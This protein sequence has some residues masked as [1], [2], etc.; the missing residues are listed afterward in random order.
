M[1]HARIPMAYDD[2]RFFQWCCLYELN[3]VPRFQSRIKEKELE[4]ESVAEEGMADVKEESEEQQ[5]RRRSGLEDPVQLH[6][7]VT[8]VIS[9]CIVREGSGGSS[10]LTFSLDGVVCKWT[11]DDMTQLDSFQLGVG[12]LHISV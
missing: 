10:L 6:P 7:H 3:Q 8:P 12:P 11:L 2:G 9:M 4:A 1:G 5:E